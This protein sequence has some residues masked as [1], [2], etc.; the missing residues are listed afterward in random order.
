M[1][2]CA[3]A[4]CYREHVLFVA[5]PSLRE[6]DGTAVDASEREQ[7]VHTVRTELAALVSLSS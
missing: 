3:S 1:C 5:P 2:M 4:N 6:L 7:A